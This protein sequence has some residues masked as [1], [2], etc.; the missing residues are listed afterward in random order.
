MFVR[1]VALQDPARHSF[2]ARLPFNISSRSVSSLNSALT[3]VLILR[4]LK[5]FRINTYTKPRERVSLQA[6]K[7]V[8]SLR[9]PVRHKPS[10]P[11]PSTPTLSLI[12]SCTC[13]LSQKL[14]LSQA[15]LNLRLAHSFAHTRGLGGVAPSPASTVWPL[16][17]P[18]LESSHS[19]SHSFRLPRASRGRNGRENPKSL[20]T[21][22]EHRFLSSPLAS[23][24]FICN[25][26]TNFGRPPCR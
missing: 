15:L 3:R 14:Y 20:V 7:F 8:N 23:I 9:P 25:T 24:S 4:H 1:P 22:H 19:L 6:P 17:H 13:A 11:A 10:R 21:Q 18:Q 5:S 16:E 26:Y 12:L 2:P